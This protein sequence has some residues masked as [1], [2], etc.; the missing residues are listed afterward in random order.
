MTK[1]NCLRFKQVGIVVLLGVSAAN[2]SRALCYSTP[3]RAVDALV[4]RSSISAEV[5]NGG[6][7]VTR[8]KS[9]PVLGQKWAMVSRCDHPDW[10]AFA[11]PANEAISFGDAPAIGDARA[12]ILVHAG[13]IVRLWRQES[14]LRFEVSGVAEESGALGKTIWVRLAHKN[15]DDY[16][17]PERFSGII[18]GQLNV[19]ILP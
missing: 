12:T 19:E 1:D 4:E 7:Q 2:S 10:P 17:T 16:S 13:E 9:D 18:R 3:R 8:I 5:R 14:L 15:A 11:V 6:Y